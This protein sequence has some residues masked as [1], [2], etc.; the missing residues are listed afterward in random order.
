MPSA[1]N[2]N[3]LFDKAMDTGKCLIYRELVK[4][5]TDAVNQLGS[6]LLYSEGEDG[7]MKQSS[8]QLYLITCLAEMLSRAAAK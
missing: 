6:W 4:Q 8:H 5:H 7:E 2:R 1:R 3:G